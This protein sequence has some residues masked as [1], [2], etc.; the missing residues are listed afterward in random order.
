[1]KVTV[2]GADREIPHAATLAELLAHLGM[3]T[4]RPGTAVARN[5]EVV[6]RAR[7]SE[8]EILE[9]DRFEIITAVQGG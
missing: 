5:G 9:G 2:N 8:T 3:A 6:P 7:W 1:M 4:D